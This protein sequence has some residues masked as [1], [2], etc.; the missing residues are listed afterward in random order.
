MIGISLSYKW[1][2]TGKDGFGLDVRK[3][4]TELRRREVDSVEL[5]TVLPGD[6]PEGVLSVARRL[7]RFGFNITVHSRMKSAE[8]AIADI[9]D[10]LRLL[11]GELKQEKLVLVLHPIAAD[12]VAILRA[13]ADH[14]EKMHYPVVIALENNRLMPDDTEGDSAAYVLD[15]V[16]QVNSPHVGLCF[17]MG[18]YMYYLKKHRPDCESN[19]PPTEFIKRTVHTHIHALKGLKTHYPLTEG[20]ELPLTELLGGV[21]WGYFGVYNFEPDLA[22]WDGAIEPLGAILDSLDSLRVALPLCARLYDRIRN[23]FERD[24]R[25]AAEVWGG[26]EGCRL[27]LANGT[28]YLFNTGGFKWAMDPGLRYARYLTDTVKHLSEIFADTKL[29]VVTHFHVDHFEAES[30]R[31]LA[32]CDMLWVIPDFMYDN[33]IEYGIR[34]DKIVVAHANEPIC[35][36]K[37]TIL[38]FTGRHFRP[39]THKGIDEYGYYITA[40]GAP[41]M[42]FPADVRDYSVDGLPDIPKADICFG[43]VWLGDGCAHDECHTELAEAMARFLLEFSDKHVVLAHLYENGRR[44]EDM[45]R[46]EHAD[47]V[48]EH[49]LAHSPG[50]KVSVPKLGEHILLGE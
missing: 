2:L 18:H 41:S 43:H 23:N 12:N 16:K 35:I 46:E 38:P 29:M 50:T 47:E 21:S 17:D 1:L 40:E 19:L 42:A 48:A 24:F 28:F 9:F 39:I 20:Y 36:E 7:R 27:S 15:V 44:D 37:L 25:R 8:S 14:I 49:I 13:L 31:E 3:T 32:K 34:P 5:R 33:A 26:N 4:L 45:W 10:P 30:V 6:S 11:L 22:R